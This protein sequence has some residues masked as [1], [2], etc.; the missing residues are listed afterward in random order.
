MEAKPIDRAARAFTRRKPVVR[1]LGGGSAPWR[2]RAC[3]KPVPRGFRIAA[4][5]ARFGEQLGG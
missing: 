5:F 2:G 3:P 4:D 1:Q